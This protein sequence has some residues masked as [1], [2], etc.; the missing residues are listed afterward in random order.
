MNDKS[1]STIIP[2]PSHA[3]SLDPVEK[4]EYDKIE[5]IASG[6][7]YLSKHENKEAAKNI[8]KLIELR[9]KY[10]FSEHSQCN[11]FSFICCL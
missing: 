5:V 3:H 4:D 7:E 9:K 2:R 10:F 11:F 1:R 6:S 8:M